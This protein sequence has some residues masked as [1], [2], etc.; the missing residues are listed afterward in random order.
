MT[1]ETSS[2]RD[3]SGNV[4]IENGEYYR[5][6]YQD[7]FNTYVELMQSGLYKELTDKALL[8][9]HTEVD[10]NNDYIK[11]RPEQI[12]FISYPYEWCFSM[13]K[14][15]AV[16]TL[17]IN[18]IAM[19]YGLQLK[20]ASAYNMQFYKNKMTLI[21]TLS[22]M[23]WTPGQPWYSYPQFLRHFLNP[24][25]LMSDC[26]A[27]LGQLSK[28]YLDG[29]PS[30]IT[31]RLL[32]NLKRLSVPYITHVFSQAMNL[33]TTKTDVVML[34]VVLKTILT[35]IDLFI[36]GLKY[37]TKSDWTQYGDAGSYTENAYNQKID[38]VSLA[39]SKLSHTTLADFGTNTGD[40]AQ[41]ANVND[42]KVVAIDNDHDCIE[43]IYHKTGNILPLVV[44][45]CNPSPAIGWLNN[46][47][48]S[49][50]ERGKFD[51]VLALALIHHLCIGNNVPLAKVAQMFASCCKHTLIIEWVPPDDKQALKLSL[52]GKKNVPAY[53]EDIFIN[54]FGNYF[55]F[56]NPTPITESDRKIYLM[57]RVK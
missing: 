5:Y 42:Y 39:L 3:P 36:R 17:E 40:F 35:N 12:P 14:E 56:A 55:S 8:I 4:V 51:T 49:F 43:S 54:E 57:Q 11:I 6:I 46:E 15:A 38:I 25:L 10:S 44:D 21:D 27:K 41:M 26:D 37:K 20:D 9:P 23:D 29:I 19:Q 13:L 1:T 50:L 16:K 34:P 22:F 7:Y 33:K 30:N 28:F 24:L 45:I 2:F 48:K 18:R 53:T 31:A 52:N 32:P 47:R